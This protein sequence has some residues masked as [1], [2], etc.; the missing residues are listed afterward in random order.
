MPESHFASPIT[1]HP[2]TLRQSLG[3][4]DRPCS[5]SELLQ[6]LIEGAAVRQELEQQ[7]RQLVSLAES[8]AAPLEGAFH[9]NT[10]FLSHLSREMRTP[11]NGIIGM[12]EALRGKHLPEPVRNCV[13]SIRQSGDALIAILDEVLDFSRIENGSM[14]IEHAD[15][16]IAALLAEV[17]QTAR[18]AANRRFLVVR[19]YV[20]PALPPIVSGDAA[21]IRQILLNLLNNAIEGTMEGEIEL[22]AEPRAATGQGLEIYFSVK[23]SGTGMEPQ[24]PSRPRQPF[25]AS[26]LGLTI[27]KRLAELM[28]GAFGV[29][30]SQWSAPLFWFTIVAGCPE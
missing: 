7:A 28:G 30:S 18:N 16:E 14:R 11:L 20:D 4:I 29:V 6:Y 17:I 3:L 26:G 2:Q 24:R 15:F 12:T 8:T 9:D 22:R 10:G 13:D 27:S 19:A 21:R 23:D 5:E 25:G 1:P